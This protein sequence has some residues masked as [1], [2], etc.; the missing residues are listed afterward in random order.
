MNTNKNKTKSHSMSEVEI[1]K[2]IL[3][4]NLGV[5]ESAENFT[6][7]SWVSELHP[8]DK[9]FHCPV[10]CLTNA[11]SSHSNWHRHTGGQILLVTHGDGLYQEEGKEPVH[12]KKGKVHSIPPNAKHW[13]GARPDS[14]FVHIVVNPNTPGN[15]LIWGLPASEEDYNKAAQGC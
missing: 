3:I 6:G 15:R 4:F 11:P 14:W 7:N 5:K 1:P 9:T 10:S 8:D 12:L 13:H 2:E